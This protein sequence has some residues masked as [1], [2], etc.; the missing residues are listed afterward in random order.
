MLPTG[1]AFRALDKDFVAMFSKL[2]SGLTTVQCKKNEKK[3]IKMKLLHH[4]LDKAK[5]VGK[6][7]FKLSLVDTLMSR[8]QI[9]FNENRSN[10]LTNGSIEIFGGV[11]A[12]KLF[13]TSTGMCSRVDKL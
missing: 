13:Y 10:N 11:G 2:A 6:I 4:R 8:W 3:N 12:L 9:C 1:E 7:D 5:F